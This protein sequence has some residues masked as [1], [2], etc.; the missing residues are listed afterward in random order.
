M[1]AFGTYISEA[2]AYRRYAE[3]GIKAGGRAG[4]SGVPLRRGGPGGRSY[5][6]ILDKAAEHATSRLSSWCTRTPRSP[7]RRSATRSA[8]RCA[9][10]QSRR[11]AVWAPRRADDRLVEGPGEGSSGP[12]RYTDY[13]GGDLPAFE[14]ARPWPP[15][16]EVD[17]VDGFLMV[18]SPW[19]VRNL[20]FDEELTFGYGFDFDFCQQ[21]RVA[22]R[23]W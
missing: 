5:N 19:A 7:I 6:V 4:L 10:Q 12:Q 17:S 15:P 3:P 18:L 8:T 21:A 22:G 20:R 9:I 23:R 13:G 2:E 16:G 11:S 14:W 1:I